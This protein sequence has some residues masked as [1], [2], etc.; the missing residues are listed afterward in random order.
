MNELKYKKKVRKKIST[1][2]RCWIILGDPGPVSRDGTNRLR[3]KS[4]RPR[5]YG[6]LA[7]SRPDFSRHFFV[8]SRLTA[9]GSPEIDVVFLS[10]PVA[11]IPRRAW[12]RREPRSEGTICKF[13]FLLLF[14]KHKQ[15]MLKAAIFQPSSQSPLSPLQKDIRENI[16][17]GRLKGTSFRNWNCTSPYAIS[18]IPQLS[19]GLTL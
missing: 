5:V 7:N 6:Q 14:K 8:S 15:H 18:F 13:L 12:T 4:G 19:R 2:R 17:F 9:R 3:A 1:E 16:E 11:G 10:Y